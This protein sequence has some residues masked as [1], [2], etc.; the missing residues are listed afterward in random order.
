VRARRVAASASP[1]IA[2]ERTRPRVT[3]ANQP[4]R[5][6]LHAL[7]DAVVSERRMERDRSTQTPAV[8]IDANS[9]QLDAP[10]ERRSVA[11]R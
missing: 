8:A 11:H 10:R 5:E 7:V 4:A 6:G 1:A 2:R 3:H 9:R